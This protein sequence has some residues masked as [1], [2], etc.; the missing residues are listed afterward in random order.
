MCRAS[1]PTILLIIYAVIG[2]SISSSL[3]PADNNDVSSFAE[4]IDLPEPKYDSNTS[5]ENALHERRS[6]RV[7]RDD[8]PLTIFEASQLLWAAQGITNAQGSR[9]AP[10]AGALYPLEVYLVIGDVNNLSAGI[11]H[12]DPVMHELI[13]VNQ[14]DKKAELS[15]AA[16]KQTTIEDCAILIVLS[17]VYERTTS[18]YGERGIRYVHMEAGHAAQNV[19]LQAVSLDLG[20]VTI[21]AFD[22]DAV[23]TTM[24]LS[25]NEQPLYIIAV[26]RT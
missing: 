16:F 11:Y 21:G 4:S 14:E 12:Y 18:K 8:E 23:R 6:I 25:E 13:K 24:N 20:T 3:Q 22:D 1:L 19:C 2:V 17:A 9:T 10:S 15:E 7:Y 5:I 26:G